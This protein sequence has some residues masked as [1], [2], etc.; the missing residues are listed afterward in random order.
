ML[1]LKEKRSQKRVQVNLPVI[2][3]Y[4]SEERTNTLE[5]TMFD[6]SK[7]GM[8]FYS[9]KPLF[10]GLNLQVHC[11]YIRDFPKVCLVKW[12]NRQ[13]YNLYKVGV[14]FGRKTDYN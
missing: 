12:C 4:S 2:Y 8:C 7:S 14:F 1:I 6:L 5:G 11:A 3:E 9:E 10:E 13:Q